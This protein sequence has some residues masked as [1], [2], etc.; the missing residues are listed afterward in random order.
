MLLR[1]RNIAVMVSDIKEKDEPTKRK[2]W[3]TKENK[4]RNPSGSFHYRFY[5]IMNNDYQNKVEIGQK[6]VFERRMTWVFEYSSRN[7]QDLHHSRLLG[8]LLCE[9]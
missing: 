6:L 8:R 5:T 9:V 4:F 7:D 2:K 3:L 1:R